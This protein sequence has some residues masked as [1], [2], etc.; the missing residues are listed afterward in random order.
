M[1]KLLLLATCLFAGCLPDALPQAVH[2]GDLPPLVATVAPDQRVATWNRAITVLLDE[3]YVPQILN[4][5]AAYI[6]A[7]RRDAATDT[8]ELAGTNVIVT[9]SPQGAVRVEIAGGG[10]YTDGSQLARDLQ[11]VQTRLTAEITAAPAST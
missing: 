9:I 8:D 5:D 7:K 2:P 1:T 6:S 10:V 4:Q 3:G 11:A